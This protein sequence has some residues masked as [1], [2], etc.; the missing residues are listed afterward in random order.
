MWLAGT[1]V[2]IN[3]PGSKHDWQ[4]GRVKGTHDVVWG[5]VRKRVAVVSLDH[6]PG[7][8]EVPIEHLIRENER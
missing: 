8:I 3:W 7:V 2:Q 4:W 5:K 6:E 1:R